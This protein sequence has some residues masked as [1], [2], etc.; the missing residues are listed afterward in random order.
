MDFKKPRAKW[1]PHRHTRYRMKS[2]LATEGTEFTENIVTRLGIE[3]PITVRL[4]AAVAL[5]SL[6][7]E[8]SAL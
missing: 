1:R 4:W 7:Q 5:C 3:W 2:N 6:W 8:V